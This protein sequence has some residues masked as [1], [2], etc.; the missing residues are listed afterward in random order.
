MKRLAIALVIALGCAWAG[1]AAE[2]VKLTSLQQIH[3]LSNEQAAQ[4][5]PVEFEATVLYYRGYERTLF[6]QDGDAA[7]YVSLVSTLNLELG[8]RVL[9]KGTTAPSFRPF[10]AAES[11]KVVGKAP[12]PTPVSATFDDLIHARYDCRWVTV[13]GRVRSANVLNAPE[14]NAALQILT[15]GGNVGVAIDTDRVQDLKAL[16][17]AE[18]E[19]TGA[20]SGVFD[21]KMQ[22]TG[23]L[24]HTPRLANI[25][26][27]K[28]ATV[29]PWSIPLTPMGEILSAYHVTNQTA[30]VRVRGTITYYQPGSALVLQDGPRSLWIMTETRN[31]L[32][33]GDIADATGL[34]DVHDG[35]LTLTQGEVQ[36]TGVRSVVA[37]HP[38]TGNELSQSKRI[39]DLV[40]IEG[41]LVMQVRAEAQDEYVLLSDGHLF[42]A[43]Y[44]HP[45]G[46]LA[47][48]APLVLQEMKKLPLR[49]KIRVTGICVLEDS[50]PF[51]AQVPF[52]LL[53]RSPDDVLVVASSPWLSVHNLVIVV[54]LL[55]L[56]VLLAAGKGWS[57]D[58]RARRQTAELAYIERRRS[59]ILEDIS[60]SRPVAEVIEQI[61][62]LVSFKLH[63]APCWCQVADGTQLGNKPP[64]LEGLRVE[65]HELAA[66]PGP[67]LGTISAAFDPH[68]KP[69]AEEQEAL[70]MA[71][72]LTALA[73]ETRRL[74]SDLL[75][76]SEYDLLTEV[77]N[78]FSLDKHLDAQ[79][80][81]SRAD[82]SVFGLIYIDLDRFKQINDLYG[83]RIGDLY[84]Q[85]ASVRMK[86]QLRSL[87]TLGRVGG[88]EFAAVVP[89]AHGR[90]E[91]AEIA[92]RLERAFDQPFEIEGLILHETA[93]VGCALY[94]EDGDTR[95]R[96][97]VAADA[98]MYEVKNRR[99]LADRHLHEQ[100]VPGTV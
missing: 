19:V 18:V 4:H 88:D 12:L 32:R 47:A 11:L 31:D 67:A 7:I 26:V 96:L 10:V 29:D 45:A 9:I 51:D 81:R 95:D 41:E 94:P 13:R 44:R 89:A 8:D 36:D 49:S 25:K 80:D 70:S 23:V 84:L 64:R 46:T 65:Q 55:L 83:H 87:D 6:V 16:I 21:G 73:I 61:T 24:L 43:I 90:V 97:L 27:I 40:T 63:G 57:V 1:A 30:R 53:L 14:K 79:I 54:C 38:S 91:L 48:T 76:R 60:G 2:P 50:N 85:R 59:R 5:I 74:Y 68:A 98:A 52:D 34:P 66:H 15:D 33:I 39:F 77:H 62:E 3:A 58:R 20:A 100:P 78:R 37:P 86:G 99:R 35:F 75:R 71:A 56:A 92:Q 69:L 17:D 42:S 72:S 82:A 93:S 22:Q 28:G